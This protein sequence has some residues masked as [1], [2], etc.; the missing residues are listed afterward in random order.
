MVR[1]LRP[2]ALIARQPTTVLGWAM[3]ALRRTKDVSVT[4]TGRAFGCSA[5]HITRV[6]LGSNKP[7]RALVLFYEER[8]EA[9]GL[10]LSLFDVVDHASEQHRRRTRGTRS[11]VTRSIPGDA[12]SFEGDTIPHGTVMPPGQLFIKT[13][14]IR[15]AGSV[16]WNGRRLERQGPVMGPGLIV[17]PPSVDVPDTPPGETA[18][19]TVGLRAP[20]YDCSSIAYFKMVDNDGRICFPDSYQLGL[21][22]LVRGA[23]DAAPKQH[24]Q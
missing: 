6:E 4:E 20:G 8:F 17:S 19:I 12:S 7:S 11:A 18:R 10:L 14:W 22:V 23:R 1:P 5:S 21:D 16:P 15:N 9:D 13:W 24:R 3:R 2:P